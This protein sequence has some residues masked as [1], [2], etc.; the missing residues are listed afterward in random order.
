MSKF[1]LILS[2]N[3]ERIYATMLIFSVSED[4]RVENTSV[5][6]ITVN[7]SGERNTTSFRHGFPETLIEIKDKILAQFCTNEKILKLRHTLV[8]NITA[9]DVP[10][11]NRK[12]REKWSLCR[13]VYTLKKYQSF[14]A[15]FPRK[16]PSPGN[17]FESRCR[18][19]ILFSVAMC[20]EVWSGDKVEIIQLVHLTL[21][22]FD[23][24]L[25]KK[26]DEIGP[27]K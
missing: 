10:E 22:G 25:D 17:L 16:M 23:L 27:T 21:E 3:L 14:K 11:K 15:L 6:W 8:E 9:D 7:S 26:L 4:L 5:S 18:W 20:D 24:S 13:F 12:N 1:F 19:D 2:F